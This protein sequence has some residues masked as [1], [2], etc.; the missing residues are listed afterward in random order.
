MLRIGLIVTTA[1]QR[2][3]SMVRRVAYERKTKRV[4]KLSVE[5]PDWRNL[6]TYICGQGYPRAQVAIL[7]KCDRTRVYNM[8]SG[9]AKPNYEQGLLL[10]K[11]YEVA[12]GD[13]SC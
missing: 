7:L 12:K 10:I 1:M 11:L 9:I 13:L 5:V 3:L 4:P 8:Q 2:D 6:I